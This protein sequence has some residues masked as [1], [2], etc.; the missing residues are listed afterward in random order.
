MLKTS[1]MS[2]ICSEYNLKGLRMQDE[3]SQVRKN[4]TRE[5]KGPENTIL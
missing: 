3:N 1:D 4:K 5:V 2:F